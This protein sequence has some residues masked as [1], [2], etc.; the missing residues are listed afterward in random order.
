MPNVVLQ[1][2][3][4]TVGGLRTNFLGFHELLTQYTSFTKHIQI[5]NFQRH[6]RL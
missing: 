3:N 6:T 2:M 1:S 5:S 4:N